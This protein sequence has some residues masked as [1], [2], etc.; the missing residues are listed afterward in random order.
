MPLRSF[1]PILFLLFAACSTLQVQSDYDPD[2][3]FK[4]LKR[5][6]VVKQTANG[7]SS[8]T[9]ERIAAAL[10]E[11]FKEKGYQKAEREKADF[12]V[13]YHTDVREKS[14][15][16]TDYQAAGLYP[17]YGYYRAPMM[18]PVQREYNYTEGKIIVD[19]LNPNGNKIFWRGVATDRLHS[20]DTPEER[21]AYIRETTEKILKAFPSSN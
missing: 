17:Y 21:E 16:V 1:L 11:A 6:A 20:Y 12:L 5:F 7:I 13:L 2:F 3:D 9:S 10:E 18:V 8:L 4:T 19:A 14:Q 15:V